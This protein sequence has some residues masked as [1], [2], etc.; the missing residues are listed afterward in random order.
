MQNA[1]LSLPRLTQRHFHPVARIV[2]DP[3]RGLDAW[4]R[5]A[6]VLALR[7]RRIMCALES[8]AWGG[9]FYTNRA[10]FTALSSFTSEAS[11]LQGQNLLPFI[12]AGHFDGA[13]GYGRKISFVAWGVLGSTGTPTYTFQ[14]R[15]SNTGGAATLSGA[16]VG[17]T[18]ALTAGSGVTNKLWK[19]ELDLICNT[20]GQGTGNTTLCCIG[21]LSSY[22]LAAPYVYPLEVTTPDTA[23]WTQTF[24]ATLGYYFNLSVTCS[25]S[26]ASNTV[27]CK[28]LTAYSW[29]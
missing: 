23:T 18:A 28:Q 3:L 29:N 9:S 5:Q 11:L 20:P 8:P 2:P 16:S 19:L 27:R 22:G 13:R 21:Q 17:V 25:A 6:H 15:L 4:E 12:P 24:D 1:L 7:Q 26:D 10:D 14:T